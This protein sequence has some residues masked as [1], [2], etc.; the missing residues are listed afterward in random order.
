MTSATPSTTRRVPRAPV[1]APP[2]SVDAPPTGA[3]SQ[4][5]VDALDGVRGIA[6]LLVMLVHG[7]ANLEASGWARLPVAMARFGWSGVDLFFVLSGW[8][9]TRILLEDRG[10]AG[11]LPAFF[12]RRAL[13]IWPLYFLVLAG[14]SVLAYGWPAF[15]PGDA[16]E[17]RR[18]MPWYWTHT[19]NWYLIVH[20]SGDTGAYGTGTFWSLALEEQFYL[21]WPFVV[22]RLHGRALA[23]TCG[24][25]AVGSALLRILLTVVGVSFP[26]AVLPFTRLEGLAVGAGLAALRDVPEAWARL[27]RWTAPLADSPVRLVIAALACHALLTWVTQLDPELLQVVG[28]PT[29]VCVWGAL[30]LAVVAHG[31]ETPLARILTV[32]PLRAVGRISYGLYVFHLPAIFLVSCAAV[33][34]R[35][36]T[37]LAA[38]FWTGYAVTFVAALLSWRLWERPWLALKRWVPR[39]ARA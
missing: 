18:A 10:R 6:I 15:Q 11:A 32:R 20:P 16:A 4:G 22:Q 5:H 24:A 8:L 31:P 12:A 21:V 17:F 9:I 27:R 25:L 26:L 1:P 2:R 28:V 33:A 14:L 37:S 13:R 23:R 30:V 29:V 35:P 38:I 34:W 19:F 7:V 36:G 3:G 39:P